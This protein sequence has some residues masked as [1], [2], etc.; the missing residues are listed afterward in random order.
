MRIN[1]IFSSKIHDLN[2]KLKGAQYI[3]MNLNYETHNIAYHKH[4]GLGSECKMTV[5]DI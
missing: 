3:Q 5:V 4:S 1:I 2:F